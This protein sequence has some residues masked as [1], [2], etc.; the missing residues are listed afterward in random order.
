MTQVSRPI[1]HGVPQIQLC[2]LLI[3]V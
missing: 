2:A 1:I 3:S